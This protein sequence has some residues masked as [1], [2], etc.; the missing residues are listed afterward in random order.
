MADIQNLL[1]QLLT[2]IYGK[3]VRQAIVDAIKQCYN[4]ASAGLVPVVN[5][6]SVDNGVEVTITVGVTSKSFIIEDG[7]TPV[8]GTDY[9]TDK[10]IAVINDEVYTMV[11]EET[12]KRG[13]LKPEFASFIKD[14]TDKT[15]VYVL[16]DG[17]IYAN[18]KKE[19][20]VTKD[21]EPKF[22]NLKDSCVFKYGKRYSL[23]SAAWKDL[24]DGTT[25]LVP[26]PTGST[27]VTIRLKGVTNH[28]SYTAVYGG[29]ST[30]SLTESCIPEGAEFDSRYLD[31]DGIYVVS[32]TKSENSAYISFNLVGTNE[33]DFEDF[34][35][36]VDEAIEYKEVTE[37][38]VTESFQNT[39]L[40]FVPADYEDRI[41]ELESRNEVLETEME[42]MK[43]SMNEVKDK[44][45]TVDE[46]A[47][48]HNA[49]GTTYPPSQLS[50][51]SRFD[52]SDIFVDLY[53][54]NGSVLPSNSATSD[55]IHAYIDE[56]VN[57]HPEYITKEIL[58]KDESENFD[59][60]RYIFC[61]SEHFAWCRQNYPK[62][63][64]WIN[65]ST[66]IY[67]TSVSPRINDTMYSTKYIGTAYGTV[68]AVSATNRSRTV[69][70]LEFV[71]YENGDIKPTI[72]YTD[73]DDE[74]NAN[75]TIT[76]N[77]VTYNRYP[78]GDLL[79]NKNKPIP[80]FIY[81]NEHGTRNIDA[82][83][84][85]RNETK[86]C[87]LVASRLI[88]DF[89]LEKQSKN[90]LYKYIRENCMLIVIP[91]VNVYGFNH[92]MTDVTKHD[93]D[94]YLNKNNVNI[95]RNYDCPGWDVMNP[96]GTYVEFGSYVGSENETQYVMNTMVESGAVVAMSLHGV[97]G[98]L[99]TCRHQGQNPN[100]DYNQDKL[101]KV[102]N[103]I[104]NNYGLQL[105]YYDYV[106]GV[107]A[108]CVNT[109][110]ITSKSPSFITQCGA[111]GGIVEFQPVKSGGFMG[112]QYLDSDVVECA[113]VQMLNLLAMWL[114][115]HLESLE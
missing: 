29:T 26:V 80:I 110:D 65:G 47:M 66:I 71:R 91:V 75:D 23:S 14:C 108:R 60:V 44:I 112:E 62:M 31:S 84:S 88:R 52:N 42:Q 111:Y 35:V 51:D 16:P 25:V 10:D 85:G 114:S 33:S 39:G 67:S 8:R 48:V 93:Y 115:D 22:T 7:Y 30:D 105:L 32:C 82:I 43:S 27:S 38:V 103:I 94:S 21:P 58:G 90:P 100:G 53:V 34:I 6:R 97:G 70:E 20:I 79:P 101:S 69:N 11:L 86:L 50:A 73:I 4:D 19:T 83:S 92:Y 63:Y 55:D 102:N 113:Y 37:I 98:M 5:T 72:I 76:K 40:A 54:E 18:I 9:W 109:P 107:P 13:Q 77:G 3:D 41:I 12:A 24:A 87:A 49:V 17:Y 81:A 74:R 45:G 46:N 104:Y 64:A 56:V 106:N 36:T 99:N 28:A 59:I 89:G 96:N 68:T 15:K 78:L 2:A 61:H 1:Q 95:N 57:A